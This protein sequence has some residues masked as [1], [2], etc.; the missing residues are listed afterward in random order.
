MV[1]PRRMLMAYN[2]AIKSNG[3]KAEQAARKVVEAWIA[4]NPGATVEQTR[5]FCIALLREICGTYGNA[6]GDAAY[7]LREVIAE[8]SGVSTATVTYAY[9]PDAAEVSKAVRYQARH[10]VDG[11]ADAF[12]D[13][14]SDSARFFA[15]R[16]ANETM[17]HLTERD[18]ARLGRTVRFARVPTGPTTCEWCLML[19]SR[20]FVYH[21]AKTAGE[22]NRFH[23]NCDCRIVPSYGKGAEV[24]GYDPDELYQ[25]WQE[26]VAQKQADNGTASVQS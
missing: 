13:G 14:V 2:A 19:A 12:L 22:A 7:A 18:A 3:G 11:D 5:D 6:A 10:L 23:R 8:A 24:E 4:E 16:G 26:V 1:L 20:G 17:Y 15:E 25:Q 21:S 9:A